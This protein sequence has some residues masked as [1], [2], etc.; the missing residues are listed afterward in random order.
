MVRSYQ[1]ITGIGAG[2]DEPGQGLPLEVA[3]QQHSPAGSLNRHHEAQLVIGR[4]P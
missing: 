3:G 1:H 2:G 4:G